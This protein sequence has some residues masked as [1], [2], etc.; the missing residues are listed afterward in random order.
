MTTAFAQAQVSETGRQRTPQTTGHDKEQKATT[1]D[2]EKKAARPTERTKTKEQ[3]QPRTTGGPG[4][5]SQG[6][7]KTGPKS[8]TKS[9]GAPN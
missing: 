5:G 6:Q 3:R 8:E 9:H 7:P 2:T 1:Q 4:D